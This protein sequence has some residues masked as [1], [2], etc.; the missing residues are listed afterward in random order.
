M[1]MLRA[2]TS[3]K[4]MM[5]VLISL[6]LFSSLNIQQVQA[7]TLSYPN[8]G[9]INYAPVPS[10][11]MPWTRKEAI[12]PAWMNFAD[13]HNG[14]YESIGKASGSHNWDIIAFK[15]GN[16]SKPAIMINAQLHGNE[17]YGYEIIYALANWLVSGDPTANRILQN[18]YVILVP[19]VDYRWGRTNYNIQSGTITDIDAGICGVDL[20]RNFAPS[21]NSTL[22]LSDMHQYGGKAADSEPE[23]QALITAWN[24]YQPLIYWTLHQ[25]STHVY[26]EGRATTQQTTD[27]KQ[28][29]SI[30]PTIASSLG[31]TGSLL[32]ISVSSKYGSGYN[33]SGKGYVIDGA[34]SHGVAGL[35]SEVRG[36]WNYTD[37]IRSD[38]NSGETYKQA[39]AIFIAMAQAA[40][41]I[42]QP[43]TPTPTHT[44]SLNLSAPSLN[45][46]W[47]FSIVLAVIASA[48]VIASELLSPYYGRTNMR[49]NKESLQKLALI[50]TILFSA[51]M[52]VRIVSVLVTLS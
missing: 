41:N 45:L 13:Q 10:S 31:A 37:S 25:G 18:N 6:A 48:L 11:Y 47:D 29:K 21:W 35:M 1:I 20:N 52:I 43:P 42:S 4:V 16:P 7:Q 38:L 12:I 33:G 8:M 23:T 44:S 39:K 24:R 9:D 26:T 50:F 19:V 28:L 2:R 3:S 27:L 15:F 46:L 40:E 5:V 14:S 36:G 32:N 22:S 34:S 49:L 51:T 17:H 30:L